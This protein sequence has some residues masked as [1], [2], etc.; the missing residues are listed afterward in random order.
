VKVVA[1]S[2]VTQ[3]ELSNLARQGEPTKITSMCTVFAESEVILL[4]GKGERRE[5]IANGVIDSVVSR[6]F[7]LVHQGGG[8]PYFLTGGL[9]DNSY[10]VGE[11]GRHLGGTVTTESRARY[12]GAIGAALQA[13]R[14]FPASL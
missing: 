1:T 12:A 13:K 2:C 3:L 5:N 7:S 11:L 9:C 8:A 14:L 10:I 4:V 6:I